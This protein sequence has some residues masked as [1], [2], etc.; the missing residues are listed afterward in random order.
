MFTVLDLNSLS[1]NNMQRVFFSN[2]ILMVLLNLLVKPIA[3]FGIDATVQNRV[4]PESYGLY[5]SL[6]NLS[7]LF[8]TLL[9]LGINNFTT[10]NLAQDPEKIKKYFG[11]VFSFRL[12]LFTVYSAFTFGLALFLGYSGKPLYLLSFLILNQFLVLSIAYLRSHFAGFHFFKTDAFIS[13][14]DRFLLILVGGIWLFTSLAPSQIKIEEFIWIQTFCYATSLIVGLVLLLKHIERPYLKWD[15]SFGM[16]LV[17]KSWP[18]ALLIVLMLLYT[19][20]DGVMLERIH[21]NGAY[22]AGVYAQGFRLLDALFMF[23]MIFAGLL[24]PI[25]SRQLKTSLSVVLDLVKASA[26]LLLGGTVII[27]FVTVFNA[28]LILGW[29]YVDITDAVGPFQFLMLGF[30]PIGMN[31][32][33]GTLLT[34]NGDLKILNSIS[35]IGIIANITT[36][37]ILIPI[38]GALGAA[39][40]TF[41]TQ[42]VT[43][44][45]QFLFCVYKFNIPKKAIGILK[46][47][48]LAAGLFAL[49]IW[50]ENSSYLMLLQI[51][52]G[53]ILIFGLSL[54]DVHALKKLILSSNKIK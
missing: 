30:F 41:G 38:Y 13:I 9:D 37:L 26:N 53:S 48:G 46:L 49:S 33:F 17:K 51:I 25:F 5:F 23:G 7:V 36:N 18:Y 19:R 20:I 50:F 12:V 14:L 16:D 21:P 54:I 32:I 2:L 45:A 6:L 24:F 1:S 44:I 8:N 47:A 40:A 34:A 3:L 10:K 29:I 52:V 15:F 4:G 11:K 31:F 27:I 43:A 39:I 28:E 42:G 35:A 22:E